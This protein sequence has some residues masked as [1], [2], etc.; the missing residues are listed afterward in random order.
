MMK[1]V[2]LRGMF[3]LNKRSLSA[4]SAPLAVLSCAGLIGCASIG[5]PGGGLYDE[6]PPV[7]RSSD[8]ADGATGV[9][10]QKFTLRF[11]ENIKLD[12]AM[13]KLTISPPQ[14]KS[15]SILSNAKTLTIELVDSLK[16]NTTYTIDLGDAVQD[17]NE[18]NPMT[19]LSLTFSTGS[20]I[21]TLQLSGILLN[22]EDLEPITG[23]YVGT[24]KVFDDG[25]LVQGDSLHG[26]DSIIALY[27]DSVFMLRPFERAGKTDSEGR[28][29]I[30]G[31]GAGRYRLYALADGN[32]NYLYDLFT[33]DVAFLDTLIVPQ[34]E[35]CL[36]YDTIYS[37]LDLFSLEM[38]MAKA[39]NGKDKD[40]DTEQKEDS[41]PIDTIIVREGFRYFPDDICLFAFNEGR[42][43]RYLDEIEWKDSIHLNLRFAARMPEPPIISLLEE[44]SLGVAAI[45]KDSWLICEPNLTNDTLV[46]WIRDSLVY[47]RDTLKLV[48]SYPFTENG[49]DV[50]VTDTIAL[51]NPVPKVDEKSKKKD[52]DKDQKS[53]S[54]SDRPV[55][56]SAQEQSDAEIAQNQSAADDAQD[57]P[58]A[59]D[60]GKEATSAGEEVTL[61]REEETSA[62]KGDAKADKAK[63]KKGKKR[64]RR[65]DKERDE[66]AVD[67][68][69]KTVFMTAALLGG[70]NKIDI[71]DRPRFETSAPLDS[72]DI[73]HLRLEQ[74][75]DSTWLKLDFR[76]EQDSLVLRRYTIHAMPHFS[77]GGIY[78]LIADSASMRD[79]Y[80]HTIDSTC[81][82]FDEKKVEDYA[83]LVFNITGADGPA[84]VQL[85]NEKDKPVKQIAVKDGQA[86]F[87][88]IAPGKYYARLVEDRNENGKF[89][90]GSLLEHRQPEKVYYFGAM[91][92]L[93]EWQYSQSWDLHAMPSSQQKPKPLIQNKPKEKTKKRNKNVE[94]LRDHPDLKKQYLKTL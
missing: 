43:N 27:P 42:V 26:I 22:A 86:K 10:K 40:K 91:L 67:S 32:T 69:P 38:A 74:K 12:N 81:L 68:V 54:K 47:R 66:A 87:V 6:K 15:P 18:G 4:F 36:Y 62:D 80:G 44:D 56:E 48:M 33:E 9:R 83:H 46:Y 89:D 84:F 41:L 93:R 30:S 55:T 50:M 17:N 2:Y 28:F 25:R 58:E 7:L 3:R 61:A 57:Q 19:G 63:G 5:S 39:D 37:K 35:P 73:S 75:K 31:L 70:K 85:L 53:E 29:K 92:D 20:Y 94:Y 8:P 59:V 64:G 51:N 23:A 14:E 13:D 79:V 24:Y 90:A 76:L 78:R 11:D 72:L 82:S 52:K 49:V 88:N 71:G 34:V 45:N 77:P 60:A 16:P 1:Y 65:K 21:D